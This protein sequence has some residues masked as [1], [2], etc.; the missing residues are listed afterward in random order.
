MRL[1]NLILPLVAYFVLCL[2]KGHAF[3]NAPG[4]EKDHDTFYWTESAMH[5]YLT[6]KVA[7]GEDVSG[8]DPRAQFPEGLNLEKDVTMGMPMTVGT[9]YRWI[10]P[11]VPLDIFTAYFQIFFSSLTA[12]AIYLLALSLYGSKWIAF[13]TAVLYAVSTAAIARSAGAYLHEDFTLPFLTFGFLSF[14]EAS[15]RHKTWWMILPAVL[16]GVA[17]N[18]WHFSQFLLLAFAATLVVGETRAPLENRRGLYVFTAAL[19]AVCLA[20]P[21]LR[22]D[23]VFTSPMMALFAGLS[24]FFLLSRK[25]AFVKFGA[26]LLLFTAM[27]VAYGFLGYGDE[28][29]VFKILVEKLRFGLHKPAD[30]NLLSFET[31]T[32]W[33]E[34]D[35]S[36][37]L[38]S[39][40]FLSSLFLPLGTW[41][42]LKLL[43][44]KEPAALFT[45]LMTLGL[46]ALYL[47][48]RR[49]VPLDVLFLAPATGALLTFKK[50]SWNFA[51]AFVLVLFGTFEAAKSWPLNQGG[52]IE[53]WAKSLSP[54]PD[55]SLATQGDHLDLIAWVK[56][57]TQKDD[58]ILAPIGLSPVI[59]ERTR[60]PIV[61]H[62]K[63]ES[64]VLREKYMTFL[65]ALFGDEETF[66]KFFTSTRAKYFVLEAKAALFTSPDSYRYMTGR[67]KLD[68]Q[69][70]VY[71][72]HFHPETLNRFEVV[73]QNPTYRVFREKTGTPAPPLLPQLIYNEPAFIHNPFA[74]VVSVL[75]GGRDQMRKG[76]ELGLAG[77]YPAAI[78]EW[79]ELKRAQP[80]IPE[81]N[82]YLCLA[83]LATG[84]MKLAQ[85]ECDEELKYYPHSRTG[86]Y[87][88]GILAEQRRDFVKARELYRHA[89]E[90]DPRYRAPRL[91]LGSK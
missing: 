44:R 4:F 70:A 28:S 68:P 73:Y 87:H 32:L 47:M 75:Q 30:P 83:H 66:H 64:S 65:D 7:Q 26:P 50:R 63:F 82:A 59:L 16:F 57:Q 14:L 46:T 74:E 18:S 84:E 89:L 71:K 17:L 6:E 11:E 81:L 61:L 19:F 88:A 37:N 12:I 40:V 15:R 76:F 5:L 23:G 72:M 77:Q 22:A 41:G 78:K 3:W 67:L 69:S 34:D 2:F 24:L 45:A 90:I 52:P 49:M 10:S 51:M 56:M 62:S 54:S 91:R 53:L 25:P 33:I 20:S 79:T 86:Y 1:F 60:R 85:D 48:A 58:A 42:A 80:G 29:H 27:I 55:P 31:R 9:L 13:L 39:L 36:P 43:R 8:L 35:N 21:L 38:F